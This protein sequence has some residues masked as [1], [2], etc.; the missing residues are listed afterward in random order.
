MVLLSFLKTVD[1]FIWCPFLIIVLVAIGVYFTYKLRFI[2]IRRLG[3]ALRCICEKDTEE[4]K[5][6]DVSP[7]ASLCTALSAT[8]GT[9]NIV[10]MA[11]AVTAGGPGAL[12]WMSVA[13]FFGMATKYAESLL[14]VKYRTFDADGK[15]CGGPMVTIDRA[16]RMRWLA[17]LFALFGVGVALFGIGTFG[18]IKSIVEAAGTF[19]LPPFLT[20]TVVTALVAV[21][22]FGGI[23]RIARAA[24]RIVPA[25]CGLYLL[26]AFAVLVLHAD[27]L[28]D[29]LSA[30]FVGAFYPQA[31]GGGVL[32]ASVMKVVQM[33][34]ARGIYS[35][36]S[37]LGSA[38]IAAAAAKTSSAVRQGLVSMTGTFFSL[39]ICC[40]TGM[41]LVIMAPEIGLF[42]PTSSGTEPEALLTACA[43]D[44]GLNST[45]GSFIVSGGILFFAFT[46]ILGWH[47]YGEVC[48]KY[49][50]KGT[51]VG[52]YKVTFLA[53]L[54]V[55][56][57]LSLE[58]IFVIADIVNG[59][60][61]LPNLVSLFLL[62]REIVEETTREKLASS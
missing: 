32:G 53:L 9:G 22:T 30:I 18:Q 45:Y 33:G 43:F 56:P 37:G 47:Y 15:V 23:R 57:F 6:G 19:H 51:G 40:V 10:G 38:P 39:I 31:I 58:T 59:L 42:G 35:N 28:L 14:A 3:F 1:A 16:L 52:V 7:L 8:I 4:G 21:I 44:A 61:A 36:E 48:F 12:F 25:M 54:T 60:M 17:R 27:R 20:T 34:I 13:A 41:V 26:F 62:R 46:T 5:K 2:Q 50:F 29:A 24:E 11:T 49:L 55:G